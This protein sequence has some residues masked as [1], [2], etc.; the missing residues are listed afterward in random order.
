MKGNLVLISALRTLF[1]WHHSAQM[2]TLMV[3]EPKTMFTKIM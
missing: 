3:T 1:V 2:L